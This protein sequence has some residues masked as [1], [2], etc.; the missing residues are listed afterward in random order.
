VS[1]FL[2]EV[3]DVYFNDLTLQAAQGRAGTNLSVEEDHDHE[4]MGAP[5]ARAVNVYQYRRMPD[6]TFAACGLFQIGDQ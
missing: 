6:R 2:P 5:C 1:A 4:G 3:D